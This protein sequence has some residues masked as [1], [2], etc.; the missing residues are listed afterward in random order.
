MSKEKLKVGDLV[1]YTPGGIPELSH[2]AERGKVKEVLEDSAF[3]VY[4][5]NNE[6]DKWQD[7]TGVLTSLNALTKGWT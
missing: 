1:T 2:L 4:N 3:V 7:Y 6:W 5:C